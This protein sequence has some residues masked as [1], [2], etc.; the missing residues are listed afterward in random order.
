MLA[1]KPYTY[2]YISI[3]LYTTL[4]TACC[5]CIHNRYQ[6]IM[7]YTYDHDTRTKTPNA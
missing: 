3:P 1:D 4:V 2:Q 5:A 7:L 6:F